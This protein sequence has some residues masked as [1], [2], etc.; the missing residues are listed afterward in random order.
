MIE[1]PPLTHPMATTQPPGKAF[2]VQVWQ[3]G[4]HLQQLPLS[5]MGSCH[6]TELIL[7]TLFPPSEVGC[8]SSGNSP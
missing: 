7:L 6:M 3:E 4:Q 8:A 1:Q 5:A 2:Y